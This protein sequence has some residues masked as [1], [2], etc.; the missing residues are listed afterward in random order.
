MKI[1]AQPLIDLLLY[2]RQ[3]DNN[4]FQK[5][6]EQWI[7]LTLDQGGLAADM[8]FVA[9][10]I[11]SNL[12]ALGFIDSYKT[13]GIHKW[14]SVKPSAIILRDEG[15]LLYLHQYQLNDIPKSIIYHRDLFPIRVSSTSVYI[16]TTP[17]VVNFSG[18]DEV[19]RIKP[20]YRH[21]L[22]LLPKISDAV[23][24]EDICIII[25][26]LS[27]EMDL[28][29]YNFHTDRWKVVDDFTIRG[30]YRQKYRFGSNRYF[31]V[32]RYFDGLIYE[33]VDPTWV[34]ILAHEILQVNFNIFYNTDLKEAKIIPRNFYRLPSVL[35]RILISDTLIFPK[36]RNGYLVLKD[37]N[38][39]ELEILSKIFI[40]LRIVKD[41]K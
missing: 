20:D 32:D 28:E 3:G 37:R 16:L 15:Y 4:L 24:D 30:L 22:S 23:N 12:T 38:I 11:R 14:S 39:S 13:N 21:L 26:G 35:Q 31:L 9:Y 41:E 7:S 2:H 34:Y 33:I 18:L 27:T 17:F 8:F 5:L 6:V 10:K 25:S 36:Y 29:S 19:P 1:S 40:A